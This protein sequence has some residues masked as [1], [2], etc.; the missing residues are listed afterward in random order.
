[1]KFLGHVMR[2]EGLEN[3]T[4]TSHIEGKRERKAEGG[5]IPNDLV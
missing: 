1:M 4:F 5:N 2:E 3:L